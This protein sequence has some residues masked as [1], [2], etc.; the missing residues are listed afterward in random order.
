MDKIQ[1]L[2]QDAIDCG[3]VNETE[4][5]NIVDNMSKQTQVNKA[6]KQK[7]NTRPDG[8][9]YTYVYIKGKRQQKNFNNIKELYD[10]LYDFYF[11][12]QKI[13]LEKLFPEFMLYRRNRGK[14]SNKTLEENMYCWNRFLKNNDIVKKSISSITVHMYISYFEDLTKDGTYTAKHIGNLKSLLNKIYDY[15]IREE[16]VELNPIK[17]IDFKEFRY[18][19]PFNDDK[20]YKEDERIKL[21]KYLD[22]IEDSYALA[23]R[24]MF[25]MTIRIGELKSFKWSD[26]DFDAKTIIV[27]NQSLT[28][29]QMKDDL[30]FDSRQTNVVNYTKK[31]TSQGKRKLYLTSEALR[32]LEKA[33]EINPDGKYIFMPNGNLMLTDTFNERLKKYCNECNIPYYSSH[34]I[35]FTTAST[36]YN[37][38]N[39]IQVSKALGHSQVATTLHYFRNTKLDDDLLDQMETAFSVG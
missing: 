26:L 10:Y 19:V 28:T 8:R 6:H 14:V 30:T 7:I 15:A 11:G 27:T 22:D 34:K 17:S 18:Y 16:L 33:R 35:R 31:N 1:N 38:Q 36:L 24:F 32:I 4:I 9:C 20:V 13:S 12:R 21:L 5:E 2:L 3:I 23:I 29:R 37:G 39:L 25:Q